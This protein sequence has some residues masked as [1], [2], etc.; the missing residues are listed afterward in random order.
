M[1]TLFLII[2]L[3]IVLFI[4]ENPPRV[5]ATCAN[6]YVNIP[7]H[8]TP[9][10]NPIILDSSDRPITGIVKL[11]QQIQ[12]LED[13]TNGPDCDQTFYYLVQ[14]QDINGVTVSLSWIDGTLYPG[15]TLSP[16]QSWTPLVAGTYEVQTF[17]WKSIG[18]PD[19]W[20]PTESAT[21]TAVSTGEANALETPLLPLQ[22]FKLGVESY[23][24]QC[25]PDLKLLVRSENDFPACVKSSSITRLLAQGWKLPENTSF[26]NIQTQ[27]QSKIITKENAIKIAQE[28]AREQHKAGVMNYSN[29]EIKANLVYYIT[30]SFPR[31]PVDHSTGIPTR[32]MDWLDEYYQNPQ[33][34]TEFEKDYLGL[35]NHRIEAGHVVWE[36]DYGRCD[37][38]I[39][40]SPMIFVDAITG[41][42]IDT[43]WLY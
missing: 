27:F 26:Q 11:G 15:Q 38:C 21:I 16:V 29:S 19:K 31:V 34:W 3:L 4:A 12:I 40:N 23:A 33:W 8:S 32:I 37:H 24:V 22:Q 17:V 39:A 25:T 14:I 5:E 13:F 41:K 9:S 7:N 6:S 35:P 18:N 10:S 42:V 30:T 20:W 28:Y 1:K 43:K 2:V 36:L